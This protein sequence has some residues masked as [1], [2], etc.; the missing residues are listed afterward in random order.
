[1][2]ATGHDPVAARRTGLPWRSAT[3]RAYA[4][5]GLFSGMAGLAVVARTY[6]GDS[7]SGGSL[8][9]DSI[10]VVLIA[11]IALTGGRGSVLTVLPAA[12]VLGLLQ[13]LIVLSGMDSY[14]RY[15]VEAVVLVVAVALYE[16]SGKRPAFLA[17]GGRA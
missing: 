12:A 6:S 3:L 13:N 1:V 10:T 11:G 2:L 14:Y 8:I 15:I 17:R 9:L 16:A 5:S 7:L 4:L